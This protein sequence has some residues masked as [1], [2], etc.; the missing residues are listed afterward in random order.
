MLMPADAVAS[1]CSRVVALRDP[2]HMFRPL[3]AAWHLGYKDLQVLANRLGTP[4][5]TCVAMCGALWDSLP[6]S[7]GPNHRGCPV[8]GEMLKSKPLPVPLNCTQAS[9]CSLKLWVCMGTS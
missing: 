6:Y 9:G 4:V 1:P 5:S 2:R 3:G 7:T 8:S